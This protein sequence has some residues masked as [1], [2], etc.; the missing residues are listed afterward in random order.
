MIPAVVPP[1]TA[2]SVLVT[3]PGAQAAQL[4]ASIAA[5]GGEPIV[6]SALAIEPIAALPAPQPHDLVIFV[7]V[8]AV[9][10]GARLIQKTASVRIAAIGKATAAA[11]AALEMPA[12]IVPVTT[13][14]SEGLLDHPDLKSATAQSVLI[15][16]GEGGRETLHDAFVA[17]GS[18]V[19]MLEVYRRVAAQVAATDVATLEA[20]WADI[21]IDVV[22][23]TSVDTYLKLE[24]LLSDRGRALLRRST[25]LAPSLRVIEAA[26]A[27]GW[28]GEA[29][30]SGG[31]DD[32]SILGTLARWQARARAAVS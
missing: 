20:R 7:S 19:T 21:G 25:L 6:F 16:R 23:A 9:E 5:L 27:N 1:L 2:L 17:S 10:H 24:T 29:L 11:L 3:R 26:R 15:V 8:H 4:A 22:T 31:A 13:A 14:T 12:D 30:I 32:A 18:Q 28:C